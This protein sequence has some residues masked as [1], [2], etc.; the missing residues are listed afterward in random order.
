[1]ELWIF[2]KLFFD[3]A[4]KLLR[5]LDFLNCSFQTFDLKL[6][7]FNLPVKLGNLFYS[8]LLFVIEDGQVLL[9]SA[10]LLPLN[11]VRLLFLVFGDVIMSLPAK[12]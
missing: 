6:L 5:F 4:E 9:V 8:L 1:M 2:V 3:I 7:F 11:I 10:F 12:C